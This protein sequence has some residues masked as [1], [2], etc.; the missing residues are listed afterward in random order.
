M[1]SIAIFIIQIY[2]KLI[3]PLLP[4][5]CRFYP[6]CSQYAV[7]ALTKYGFLK[8]SYLAVRRILR[9]HPFYKGDYYDPVK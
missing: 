7:D 3:S 9:C 8:G 1:K 6:T 2:R 5:S 4:P